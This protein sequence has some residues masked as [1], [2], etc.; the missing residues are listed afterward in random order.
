MITHQLRIP[1]KADWQSNVASNILH[2]YIEKFDACWVPDLASSP[3]L[4]GKLSHDV[5]LEI[6]IHYIGA[7]SRFSTTDL[8]HKY[9]LAIILSGP[10]PQ[11]TYLESIIIGQLPS[12]SG[13]HILV[14]GT[15]AP[16]GI[17]TQ[18]NITDLEVIDLADSTTLNSILN[19]SKLV[20]SRSGYTTI[21]DL[22]AL[23]KAAILIPTPGQPEQEFLAEHLS[24]RFQ[25]FK[26]A[27]QD[28]LN[29]G[30]LIDVKPIW[31]SA[32]IDMPWS[33]QKLLQLL[34]L[35]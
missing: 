26:F 20:M 16:L 21:M 18:K 25:G 3:N 7:V 35:V 8:P 27:I 14:R 33:D 19:K 34:E 23:R 30:D 11:R 4:S 29:L 15:K 22:V 9:D 13:K 2:K 32:H 6:P 28:N 10:E 1:A 5:Q 24:E 17:E 31:N 12:L